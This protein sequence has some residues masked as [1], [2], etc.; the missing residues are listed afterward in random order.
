MPEREEQADVLL[1][2]SALVKRY[3]S[4]GQAVTA[5]DGISFSAGR[6]TVL[7]I[8]GP[9]GSGKTSTIKAILGLITRD[10]GTIRVA[11]HDPA[12]ERRAV[13][14]MSGAVLEGARNIYW[15]LTV[16]ENVRYFAGLRGLSPKAVRSREEELLT[17]LGLTDRAT[18]RVGTLSRGYQQRCAI[19][20]ALIHDPAVV[21]LDE[22]TLGLDVSSRETIRT[23]VRD[24]ARGGKL[25]V[26]TSH[27]M[28]FIERSC[29]RAL[30]MRNGS[31]V[32]EGAISSLMSSLAQHTL[33]LTFGER[34]PELAGFR[35]RWGAFDEDE[36]GRLLV[37]LDRPDQVYDVLAELGEER[38]ALTHVSVR[39]NDFES[40]FVRLLGEEAAERDGAMT[41]GADR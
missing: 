23:S 10:G 33:A 6:G 1:E 32:A 31:L 22:P 5:V 41:P 2:V 29:D 15:R 36:S 4:G 7:G 27:D 13:L 34:T 28:A 16:R 20:C 35:E 3:R 25:V 9:N 18:A 26:I 21:F 38:L 11:G 37:P 8:L 24:W 40:V 12:G 30:V 17:L 14:A 19:A 39:D